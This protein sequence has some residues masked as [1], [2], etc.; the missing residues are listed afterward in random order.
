MRELFMVT[1]N[2]TQTDKKGSFL[3]ASLGLAKQVAPKNAT[4]QMEDAAN[5]RGDSCGTSGG[6]CG[7]SNAGQDHS[8]GKAS[9]TACGLWHLHTGSC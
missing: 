2:L 3:E 7:L 8:A 4:G 6:E 1:A 5:L 9:P